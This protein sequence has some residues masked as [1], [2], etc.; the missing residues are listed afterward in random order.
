[1]LGQKQVQLDV[2]VGVL[3][4]LK[5]SVRINKFGTLWTARTATCG[6][7]NG[8]RLGGRATWANAF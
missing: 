5:F 1:V 2:L 6:R 8:L 4:G 7:A 3:D